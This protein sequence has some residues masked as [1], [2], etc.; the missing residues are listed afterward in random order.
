M[1]R[2]WKGVLAQEDVQTGDGRVL[3]AGA[4]EWADLPLP[5]AWLKDGDQHV[6]PT[7]APQIGI[8]DSITRVGND[9]IGE[10]EIDDGNPDGMEV[11]R[12]M[13]EGT[14]PGGPRFFVSIDPDDWEVEVVSTKPIEEEDEVIL[15]ASGKGEIPRFASAG[16]PDPEDGETLFEQAADD[17]IERATR[18]RIRGATLC[19]VS[20]FDGA[21]IELAGDAEIVPIRAAAAPVKPPAAWFADPE[22]SELQRFVTITDEGRVFGHVAGWDECH[23]GF[24]GQ[25]LD[26]PQ[27]GTDYAHFRVGQVETSEKTMIPTGPIALKGGHAPLFAD[28]RT[29]QAHYDNP[30][31]AAVDVVL[32]EDDHGIWFAGALRPNVTDSDVRMLR[33]SG[34][35]GDWRKIG[36]RL[37]L[38]GICSVNT[39]GYPK[40]QARVASGEL[41][42]LVAAGGLPV[43]PGKKDLE[44]RVETLERLVRQLNPLI[45]AELRATL[46]ATD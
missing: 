44:M 41:I 9:I 30:A 27:S 4:V 16:D 8:I 29:A 18:L 43:A 25:C 11:V 33:A 5:L 2:R 39:P 13:E 12:R 1:G 38:I 45:L 34:V 22:L 32:G 31:S 42:A 40:L 36:G 7:I 28:V 37:E 21:F 35:S 17:I 10:G 23:I 3:K 26:P 46:T 24:P 15:I 20:A 14:A 19:A 6:N